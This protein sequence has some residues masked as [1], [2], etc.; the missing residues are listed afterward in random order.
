ML[1][2]EGHPHGQPPV[3]GSIERG[4]VRPS[5]KGRG[6]ADSCPGVRPHHPARGTASRPRPSDPRPP[7]G[8]YSRRYGGPGCRSWLRDSAAAGESARADADVPTNPCHPNP[9]LHSRGAVRSSRSFAPAGHGRRSA[10]RALSPQFGSAIEFNNF[11][12]IY[13]NCRD[14]I[15]FSLSSQPEIDRHRATTHSRLIVTTHQ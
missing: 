11:T 10:G 9:V 3:G 12:N 5:L 7:A 8:S 4:N 13:R 15:Y 2:R 1:S 14:T 6:T